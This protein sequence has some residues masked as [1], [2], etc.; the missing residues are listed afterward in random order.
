MRNSEKQSGPDNPSLKQNQLNTKT[1]LV[2]YSPFKTQDSN[3]K[4]TF[5]S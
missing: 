3:T 4:N 2:V 1:N 5:L